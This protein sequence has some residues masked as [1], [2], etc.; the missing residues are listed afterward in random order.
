MES[1][2][3][4]SIKVIGQSQADYY[5]KKEF[6]SASGLKR[7]KV[8]PAHFKFAEEKEETEA[9]IFGSAYH[10][11]VL[12]NSTFDSQYFVFDDT[13][14]VQELLKKGF[15][16]P[17]NTKEYK[18]WAESEKQ[19]MGER[20]TIKM[21]SYDT[22]TAMRKALF[23]FPFTKMLLSNG[24]AEVG[25]LCEVETEA[26]TILVKLKPD[27]IKEDKKL[28]VDLKTT[29]DAS[30]HGFQRAAADLD[31]QIQ[32]ALYTDILTHITGEQH[33]F[34]FIAQEKTVPYAFN[35]FETSAQFLSQG[36][37]EY[38]LLLQLYKT[39]VD[40]DNWPGYQCWIPNKYGILEL[41]LP[42]YAIRPVD[43]Y[44]HSL[45]QI[46]HGNK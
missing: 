16:I 46:E 14:V 2:F 21:E 30:D 19:N 42:A 13:L 4:K 31:M 38:E 6:I 10:C 41:N 8:S 23:D 44:N 22:I 45:K 32:A 9:M 15:V 7:L 11:Y 12:E 28:I 43:Y 36:R 5:D 27:Y 17:R 24:K 34:M 35:I 26:G 39:C 33:S 29:T 1:T 40:N 3:I 37:Y 20:K 18:A 25:Y